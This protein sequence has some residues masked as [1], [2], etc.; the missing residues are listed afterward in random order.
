MSTSI[1]R[2]RVP[3]PTE[4]W[5]EVWPGHLWQGGCLADIPAGEFDYVLTLDGS[6]HRHS[7]LPDG[8]VGFLWDI[9]D[10]VMPS[11][12][13]CRQWAKTLHDLVFRANR[14]VLVRCAAGLNRSGLVVARILIE[15][16]FDA[17]EAVARVRERRSP[18][19]LENPYFVEWLMTERAARG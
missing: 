1:E 12:A 13:I 10:D 2:R 18:D 6:V 11:A 5:S 9:G 4:P 19:A 17:D 7:P 15:A 16:G 8:T 14:R 3:V